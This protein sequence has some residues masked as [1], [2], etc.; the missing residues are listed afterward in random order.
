MNVKNVGQKCYR[1]SGTDLLLGIEI[2]LVRID[3]LLVWVQFVEIRA[4]ERLMLMS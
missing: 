2:R 1:L 3:Y 4:S